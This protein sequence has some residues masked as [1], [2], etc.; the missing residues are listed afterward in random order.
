MSPS[1][2]LRVEPNSGV[3]LGLQI[4][5]QL[6]LAVASGRLKPG[7]RLPSARELAADLQV[8]F[9]TVRKAYGD[10]EIDGVLVLQR[11]RGTFVADGAT[12]IDDHE[13]RMLVRRHVERL[14][15][16][17]AGAEIDP[18]RL[19]RLLRSELVRALGANARTLQ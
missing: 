4:G 2:R 9:H 16:D 17:L 15:E 18:A 6:R 14:T 12:Q 19:E 1:L 7:D 10:L 11:G 3:P 13:L 8:N 5:R